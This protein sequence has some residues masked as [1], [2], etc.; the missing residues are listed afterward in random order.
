MFI[1]KCPVSDK[2]SLEKN[3]T[4]VCSGISLFMLALNMDIVCR[5]ELKSNLLSMGY[6]RP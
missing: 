6:Q 5:V 4:A 1:S 3:M 2:S